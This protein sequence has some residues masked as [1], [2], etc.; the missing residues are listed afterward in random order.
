MNVF[1][2]V[3][4]ELLNTEELIKDVSIFKPAENVLRKVFELGQE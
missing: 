1:L 4:E 2:S 3:Y